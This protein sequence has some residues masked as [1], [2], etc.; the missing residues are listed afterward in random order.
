M[1]FFK[2]IFTIIVIAIALS[3][4]ATDGSNTKTEIYGEIY[5]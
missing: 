3:S 5:R 2:R 1:I 4:C